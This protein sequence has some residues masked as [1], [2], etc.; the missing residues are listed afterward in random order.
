MLG[1]KGRRSVQG[2]LNGKDV[3]F[4]KDLAAWS[5]WQLAVRD[6][7]SKTWRHDVIAIAA[8][9]RG[10]TRKTAGPSSCSGQ[11]E[12][13]RGICCQTHSLHCLCNYGSSRTCNRFS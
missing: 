10:R 12:L 3:D 9:G 7:A 5:C 4:V 1:A 2:E 11:N 6:W 8:S 13:E